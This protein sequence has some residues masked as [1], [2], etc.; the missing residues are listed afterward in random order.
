MDINNHGWAWNSVS[1]HML[2]I[3]GLVLLLAVFANASEKLQP[4]NATII[5]FTEQEAGTGSYPVTMTVTEKY[6]RIDDTT[7]GKDFI[8]FS[9]KD[10]IIYSVS[11][12]YQQIVTIKH[13]PLNGTSPIELKVE[14]M[15]LPVDKA[16]PMIAGKSSEHFQLMVNNK[17][18]RDIVAVPGLLPDTV[19]ALKEFKQVLAGQH[20]STLVY[21]PADVHE[22]CDLAKNTFYPTLSLDKGFPVLERD[23]D[24][25][26]RALV[27][28]FQQ[29][30]A[31]KLFELP[32]NYE[33]LHL[34]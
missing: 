34:K 2:Q 11:S 3:T 26:S 25:Y 29:D 13:L 17:L 20:A 23:V 14:L 27:N 4:L 22:D 7:A 33:I 9:R 21:L 8:L 19:K 6:L 1:R 12:E 10:N 31:A 24:G 15:Q 28:F 32:A 18:C 30:V 16:A 5:H